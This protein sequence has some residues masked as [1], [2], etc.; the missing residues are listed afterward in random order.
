MSKN[1]SYEIFLK[2]KY[3]SLEK[4]IPMAKFANHYKPFFLKETAYK[5]SYIVGFFNLP[6]KKLPAEKRYSD[7]SDCYSI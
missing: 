5:D 2:E 1:S 6:E 4:V 7:E 3:L